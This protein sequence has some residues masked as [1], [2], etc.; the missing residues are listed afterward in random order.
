[1][2]NLSCC[3]RREPEIELCINSVTLIGY[4][5]CVIIKFDNVKIARTPKERNDIYSDYI[6]TNNECLLMPSCD[7]PC[8]LRTVRTDRK[9]ST[10]SVFFCKS[11]NKTTYMVQDQYIATRKSPNVSTTFDG[12]MIVQC[13]QVN[14]PVST[15]VI[16]YT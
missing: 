14:E 4:D 8:R 13:A 3:Q 15:I 10:L 2:G 12:D 11:L 9:C 5:D 16:E 6:P 7:M 1:M